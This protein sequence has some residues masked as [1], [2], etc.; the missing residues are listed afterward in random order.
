[1]L[2]LTTAT[3]LSLIGMDAVH[4]HHAARP[5]PGLGWLRSFGR[6][7]YEVYL[8]H[9]FV[10]FGVQGLVLATLGKNLPLGYLWYLPTLLLSWVP[11]YIIYRYYTGPTDRYLR[12][13][14]PGPDVPA[15]TV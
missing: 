1:M 6:L 14:L 4:E 15:T 7:S 8:T 11:G 10:V 2:L 9:M 5:L 12:R 3:A 13:Q